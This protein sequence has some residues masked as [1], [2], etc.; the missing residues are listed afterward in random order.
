MTDESFGAE[1]RHR[2]RIAKWNRATRVA[3]KLRHHAW[4]LLHNAVAHPVIGVWPTRASVW[5]HD[6][7]SQQLNRRRTFVRS[8]LPVI[9]ARVAW[10]KHNVVAHLAIGLLPS[11]RTFRWHDRTASE[12]NVRDW[13]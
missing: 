8:P 10:I 6:W 7:T 5:F 12:M 13:I 9:E 4:W 11:T 3:P 1:V 2:K